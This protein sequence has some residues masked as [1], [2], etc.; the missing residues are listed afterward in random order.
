M[1]ILEGVQAG[2]CDGG[3]QDLYCL[4]S[5]FAVGQDDITGSSVLQRPSNM[6]DHAHVHCTLTKAERSNAK[7]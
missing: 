6:S 7:T 4:V 2:V 5:Q 1:I 3:T